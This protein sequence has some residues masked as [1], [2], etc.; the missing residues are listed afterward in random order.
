MFKIERLCLN[1]LFVIWEEWLD[2]MHAWVKE[3]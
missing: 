1:V 3:Q 2:G